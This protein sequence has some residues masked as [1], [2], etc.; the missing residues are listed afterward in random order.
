MFHLKGCVLVTSVSRFSTI[1][2]MVVFIASCTNKKDSS[3]FA[4]PIKNPPSFTEH[5]RCDNCGMDRNKYARTRYVFDSK[6]GRFYTC[7]IACLVVLCI[8]KDVSP[9]NIKVAEYLRPTNMIDA[10]KAIYVVGS[11]AKGTMT[12]ISK[13]AFSDKQKAMKF[14]RKYGGKI[15]YFQDVLKITKE[16]VLRGLRE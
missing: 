2:L 16:E 4:H 5:V 11:K 13:I 12:K 14:T 15:A 1:V 9:E 10:E 6:K 3:P 7:S 8:K